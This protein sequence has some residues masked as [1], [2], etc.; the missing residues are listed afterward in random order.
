MKNIKDLGEEEVIWCKTI[1]ECE[2]ISGLLH[3]N[4]LAWK[5]GSSYLVFKPYNECIDE[6]FCFRPKVGRFDS[7]ELYKDEGYIIHNAKD[8]L[9]ETPKQVSKE[10]KEELQDILKEWV[11]SRFQKG[12]NV[13]IIERLK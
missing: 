6:G 9:K 13:I 8:F 2:A 12:L 11:E 1:S 10:V 4:G 5:N 7:L 3:K